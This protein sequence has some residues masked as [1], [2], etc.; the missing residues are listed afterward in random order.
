[1]TQ[2]EHLVSSDPNSSSF[3]INFKARAS[4][5]GH[6]DFI[7]NFLFTV[8]CQMSFALRG[9]SA[10][11]NQ[12]ALGCQMN[13]QPSFAVRCQSPITVGIGS[14]D[15]QFVLRRLTA[16]F[17]VE[18]SSPYTFVTVEFCNCVCMCV[19][20]CG[21][22]SVCVMFVLYAL[23]VCAGHPQLSASH[24]LGNPGR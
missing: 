22:A 1:M 16:A 13:W 17:S 4:V 20:P 3:N 6:Q 9:Q 18:R 15:C 21:D 19:C 24:E 11:V 5:L 23:F 12:F 14:V 7:I 10:N 8:G 2:N